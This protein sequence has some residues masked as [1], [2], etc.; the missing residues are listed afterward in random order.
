MVRD[1]THPGP[2]GL[3]LPTL[4][5]DTIPPWAANSGSGA[6]DGTTRV[7]R[8]SAADDSRIG[9]LSAVC[10][11]AELAGADVLW[12]CD[13]IFWH[14]PAIECMTALTV[15]AG[16][17]RSAAVGSCV[18][19]L[20]LRNASVV[21]KQAA[22]IQQLSGGRLILG[23][24]VGSHRG[25]YDQVGADY[26]RRGRQLDAG[27]DELHRS[28]TSGA[29]VTE[30]DLT[31]TGAG[32]YRQLPAPPAVPVWVGGSSENALRRAARLGEGWIP[33]FVDVPDYAV[34]LE[35]LAKETD[36]AGRP[37]G[38]VLPAI[39]LFVSVDSDDARAL[40]RGTAWMSSLYGIPA[41]A[42]ARHIVSGSAAHV[43]GVVAAYRDA[44]AQ[45]VAV[46]VTD[47]EPLDQFSQLQDALRGDLSSA[48]TADRH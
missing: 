14:R 39:V 20:P 31:D 8:P 1:V 6:T 23:V 36:R 46:Y 9:Q 24:G 34:A 22:S 13:H 25:E 17:T 28:W 16:A 10:H 44:G 11:D 30:G 48:T 5:Q 47:D 18:L 32:R 26:R 21:A 40:E 12:V 43:A 38:S 19:Q 15:A 37:E 29:G 27:I 7:G 2:V 42:F 3:V 45:H 35:R 41:K 4:P 33:L